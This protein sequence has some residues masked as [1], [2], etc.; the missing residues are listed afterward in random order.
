[1]ERFEMPLLVSRESQRDEMPPLVSPESLPS[2]RTREPLHD[3]MPPLL[4]WN[5]SIDA[6]LS[7]EDLLLADVVIEQPQQ[8]VVDLDQIPRPKCDQGLASLDQESVVGPCAN[9]NAQRA[10]IHQ[11]EGRIRDL[12]QESRE[13]EIT[14]QRLRQESRELENTQQRLRQASREL[15]N[16]QQH[17]RQESWDLRKERRELENIHQ[18]LLGMIHPDADADAVDVECNGFRKFACCGAVVWHGSADNEVEKK[19]D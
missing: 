12:R 19:A 17:L 2:R 14:Q 8:E 18:R 7:E 13:L 15:E 6:P 3:V 10:S 1:V 4:S 5:A 16:T 11:L 9:C